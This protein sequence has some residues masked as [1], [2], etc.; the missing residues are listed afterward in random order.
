MK[1]VSNYQGLPG[2][3][4]SHGLVVEG[5]SLHGLEGGRGRVDLLEDDEGLTPHLQVLQGHDVQ[6]LT[7]L[8]EDRV[9]RFLQL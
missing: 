8:R 1:T 5:E 6:D 3:C 4:D 9:K 2:V 7:E